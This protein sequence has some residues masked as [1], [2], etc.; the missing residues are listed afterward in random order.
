[1]ILYIASKQAEHVFGTQLGVKHLINGGC[2]L[3]SANEGKVYIAESAVPI[4]CGEPVISGTQQ[5][6]ETLT[7]TAACVKGTAT[8]RT[9][10]WYRNGVAITGATNATYVI[11]GIDIGKTLTVRQTETNANGTDY[12]ETSLI[13]G[14]TLKFLIKVA[15][16]RVNFSWTNPT[17]RLWTFPAGTVLYS[18]G[19]T[20]ISTSTAENPDVTI[21]AGGGTITLETSSWSGN[22]NLL[23]N[24]TDAQFVGALSDLPPLNYY[25]VLSGCTLITGKLSDLPPLTN[26]LSLASCALITGALSDLPPLTYYL[27][28]ASCSLVTVALSDLPPLTNTIS[29]YGCNLVTGSLSDLPPLTNNLNLYGCNLITGNLSDLPPLTYYLSLASCS[30][31]TGAYTNVTGASVPSITVL[32]GTGMSATDMDNTLIAYALTTKNSGSFTATGKTRTAASN[33]AVTTLEGRGWTISGL[34]VV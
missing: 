25:L 6:G 30:L 31:V 16:G 27:N 34:S 19:V 29:L 13:L 18:D 8:V 33:A 9:W 20:P 23:D 22:Y 28:L 26:T 3:G 17:G 15:A 5:T 21:P 10:Q 24:N 7:A 11:L 4:I 32:T 14:S 1:M 12:A 2:E